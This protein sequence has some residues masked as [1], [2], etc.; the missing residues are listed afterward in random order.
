MK[1]DA[2]SVFVVVS[3]WPCFRNSDPNSRPIPDYCAR[4]ASSGLAARSAISAQRTLDT[5]LILLIIFVSVLLHEFGHCFGARQVGG[6]AHEILIWPLGGLA[7]LDLPHRP[8]AHLIAVAAGPAVN[9]LLCVVTGVILTFVYGLRPPFELTWYPFR[10]ELSFGDR[11]ATLLAQ[12]STWNGTP[13]GEVSLGVAL[14][15]R[16][17]W[18][19]WILFLFNLLPGFPLD[20]GR[21]LQGALWPWYGFRQAT[22]VAV[23][24]GFATALVIVV[25]AVAI[26]DL[27]TLCLAFFIFTTCRQQFIVLETGGDDSPFGYD[28]SQGYTSLEGDAPPPPR[29]RRPSFFQRWLQRRTQRRL[30]REV[31]NREFEERRMDQLLEKVQREGLTSLSDEE[32]RFLKRVSDRYKHR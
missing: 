7:A 11:S 13:A 4:P 8:R 2:R 9:I 20:G 24:V 27:L 31:E 15:A 30:Q 18:L 3:D 28:F 29:R 32:R 22:I 19:N 12:L 10:T 16:A 23:Y 6:D 17:F 25:A 21:M 14:L 5:A 1:S 26:N